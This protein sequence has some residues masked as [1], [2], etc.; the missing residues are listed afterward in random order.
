MSASANA[1]AL[2]PGEYERRVR[3]NIAANRAYLASIGLGPQAPAPT[4][5]RPRPAGRHATS[6]AAKRSPRPVRSAAPTAAPASASAASEEDDDDVMRALPAGYVCDPLG[7]YQSPKPKS[8]F[9]LWTIID[10]DTVPRWHHL[11]VLKVRAILSCAWWD[12][13]STYL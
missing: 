12:P 4:S 6:A 9:M 8:E 11:V 10:N 1:V 7:E 3:D 5:S 2:P 13:S